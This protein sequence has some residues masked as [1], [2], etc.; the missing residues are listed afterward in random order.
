[1]EGK[2]MSGRR[3]DRNYRGEAIAKMILEKYQP[4]SAEEVQDALKDIFGPMFEAMLQG[5]MDEHLGY[6][7][8]DHGSKS[9]E[10]RRNGYTQKKVKTSYGEI[11]ISVPRDRESSFE[12]KII[13]KRIKDISG[14]EDKILSMYAKGM[15]QR[16]IA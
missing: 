8:N 4:K 16:D 3:T 2:I 10:N 1:M 9:T 15:S 12:P 5:E 13:P 11:P 14:M 6:E 7:S